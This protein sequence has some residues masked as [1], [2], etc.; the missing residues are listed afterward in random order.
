MQKKGEKVTPQQ[1]LSLPNGTRVRWCD[2]VPIEGAVHH[3]PDGYLVITWDDGMTQAVPEKHVE[4]VEPFSRMMALATIGV[5][6]DLSPSN[7]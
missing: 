6:E 1:L 2:D 5:H 3:T 4:C 7:N